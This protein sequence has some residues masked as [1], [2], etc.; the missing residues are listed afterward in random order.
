MAPL[1]L[2]CPVIEQD[3][4]AVRPGVCNLADVK[5]CQNST[6]RSRSRNFRQ[7][8][9]QLAT[10]PREA[11]TITKSAAKTTSRLF[12]RQLASFRDKRVLRKYQQ[13]VTVKYHY[14]ALRRLRVNSGSRPLAADSGDACVLSD[15]RR[16]SAPVLLTVCCPLPATTEEQA[17]CYAPQRCL[18]LRTV[19][20]A[21]RQFQ[22]FSR[23]V[24][25]SEV[26]CSR[27]TAIP[28]IVVKR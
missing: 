10:E 11:P 27:S 23:C 3:R 25:R 21:S 12:A 28:A 20:A 18:G 22:L 7:Q 2:A 1:I 6:F 16:R 4:Q 14:A 13:F 15:V 9:C 8:S 17:I 5:S 19:S 24:C 26:G